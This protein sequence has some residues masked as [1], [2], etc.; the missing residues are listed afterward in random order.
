MKANVIVEI[1]KDGYYSCYVQEEFEDFALA[2]YGETA[3]DAKEDL[4]KAYEDV[5]DVL[6]EVGKTVPELTFVWHYDMKSF[7]NYF[8]FLNIS[9]VAKYAGINSSLMR[10]YVA[11]LAHPGEKQ[12]AKLKTAV[13]EF[14]TELSGVDF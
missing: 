9:K 14:A 5:K 12:Y 11:G 6:S 7:F 13:H 2:G 3:K 1:A 4:I 10:K 8:D